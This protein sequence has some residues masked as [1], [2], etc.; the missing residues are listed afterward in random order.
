M[1]QSRVTVVRMA[2]QFEISKDSTRGLIVKLSNRRIVARIQ[3][4]E[5]ED[6]KKAQMDLLSWQNITLRKGL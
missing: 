5:W 4:K 2:F 6:R 3:L 1:P